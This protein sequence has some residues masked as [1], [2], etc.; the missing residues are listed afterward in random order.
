MDT[1]GDGFDAAVAA[2][3]V[4]FRVASSENIS[5]DNELDT[6]R[7]D[8]PEIQSEYSKD[9]RY[10]HCLE[11]SDCKSYSPREAKKKVH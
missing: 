3:A 10:R 6:T 4:C 5:L 9:Q 2:P 1:G 7:S 11:L 8:T